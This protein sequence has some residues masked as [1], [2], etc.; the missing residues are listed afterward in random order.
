MEPIPAT[1]SRFF[2][3]DNLRWTMIILVVSMHSAVTYSGFGSWYYVEKTALSRP[4]LFFFITYQSYLQAFFMGFLFFLAGY[5]VPP[6]FDRKGAVL[7]LRDRAYRL[8]LPV[9]FYIFV[10]GPFTEYFVAKSWRPSKP[11][12]FAN[13]WVKHIYDG[14]FLS[15]TAPLWFCLAL[16]LFCLSYTGLR[17]LS[18][19]PGAQRGA[20]R[21]GTLWWFVCVVS[22]ATF[23]VRLVQP[24]GTSF[25]NMQLANFSQYVAMFVAGIWAYNGWLEELRYRTGINWLIFALAG[26]FIF[27]CALVFFGKAF[28][29]N[30]KAYAGGLHWQAAA[31][32]VWESFVCLG[33]LVLY[34]E[35]FNWQGRF[36]RLISE[37]AFGVYVLHPPVVTTTALL[38]RGVP[39]HPVIKFVVVTVM[40]VVITFTASAAILRRLPGLRRI[41]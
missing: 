20:L 35:K 14:E 27:S 10:L 33:L 8:G 13:E 1:R 21:T 34:R 7:F 30:A 16:L 41:L 40:S 5:F 11:S 4:V 25:Y 23:T 22:T 15:G 2:Y 19:G 12:S 28:E 24:A 36:T 38:L 39:L 26:G 29:G 3:V 37:N 18:P 9:L 6:S 17:L 32:N 31:S